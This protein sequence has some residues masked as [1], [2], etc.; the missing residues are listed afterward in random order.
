MPSQTD[1]RQSIT[2]Q[3]ISAL[4]GGKVPPW[5]RPWKLGKNA[6]GAANLVS[7]RSYRGLNPILLDMASD[8]HVFSSK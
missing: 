2:D 5:R 1:I 4:E 6:G 3:I 8:K 7:K